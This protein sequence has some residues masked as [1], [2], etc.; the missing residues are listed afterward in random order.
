MRSSIQDKKF[1]Q[2]DWH[3]ISTGLGVT[4]F[5]YHAINWGKPRRIVVVNKNS[6]P[7]PKRGGQEKKRDKIDELNIR[8]AKLDPRSS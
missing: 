3:K 8:M 6:N 4:S 2:R 5:T 1:N 7:L